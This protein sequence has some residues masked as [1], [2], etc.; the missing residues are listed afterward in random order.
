M[1]GSTIAYTNEDS[2]TTLT[3]VA[4]QQKTAADAVMLTL[5]RK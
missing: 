1:N 2:P 4:F 5:T 3:V